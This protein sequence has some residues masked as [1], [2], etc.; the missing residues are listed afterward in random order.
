MAACGV[1]KIFVKIDVIYLVTGVSAGLLYDVLYEYFALSAWK[2]KFMGSPW[3]K[4]SRQIK[5][6]NL[7]QNLSEKIYEN[8]PILERIL[9]NSSQNGSKNYSTHALIDTFCDFFCHFFEKS[10][11]KNSTKAG[12]SP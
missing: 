6:I 10:T 1:Y 4:L 11:A 2:E 9:Y 7:V 3:F 12:N 8:N 5:K